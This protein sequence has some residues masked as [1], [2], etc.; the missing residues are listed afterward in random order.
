MHGMG[1]AS[2]GRDLG[3]NRGPYAM[4][5]LLQGPG[6]KGL[7]FREVLVFSACFFSLIFRERDTRLWFVRL[8]GA[9]PTI[10]RVKKKGPIG[11]TEFAE[12]AP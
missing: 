7:S 4:K 12:D 5:R 11:P 2:H 6:D 8:S 1:V 3:W 9:S 10:G